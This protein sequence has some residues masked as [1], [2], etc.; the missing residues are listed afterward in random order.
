MPLAFYL[1]F[2]SNIRVTISSSNLKLN[3]LQMHT[4]YTSHAL[5]TF[6]RNQQNMHF[7]S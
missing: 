2:I 1:A 7:K 3:A 5:R 4:Y 6:D